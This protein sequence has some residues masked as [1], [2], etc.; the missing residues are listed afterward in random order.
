MRR[1][2][3]FG[4][5]LAFMVA[6][7]PAAP[8]FAQ[9]DAPFCG[10]LSDDDCAILEASA[11][12]DEASNEGAYD[13]ALD[14]VLEGV[15]NAPFDN[16]AFTLLHSA[17]YRTDADAAEEMA[18]MGDMGDEMLQDA[19]M[20]SKIVTTLVNGVDTQQTLTIQFPADVAEA[21]G[22]QMGA[23]LPEEITIN[24]AI[25]DG[26]GYLDLD[27]V[28][29]SF[30]EAEGLTGW[31]GTELAPILEE[32]LAQAADDPDFQAAMAPAM[33]G[34]AGQQMAEEQAEIF[35]QYID[36]QRL[37]DAEIDGEA[38]AVFQSKFDFV[39]FATDPAFFDVIVQQLEALGEDA[40]SPAELAQ[41]QFM[42][43]MIA[44]MLF[45]GLDQSTTSYISLDTDY[46]LLG[47]LVFEWDLSTLAG[48]A[49]FA[50]DAL[51]ELP[52]F[53]GMNVTVDSYD[54]DDA[55]D[56]DAPE[57]AMVVPAEDILASMQ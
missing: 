4:L 35:E 14:V 15:P 42:M 56:I 54:Q 20:M 6:L 57:G 7:L 23:P 47:E 5:V 33:M 32:V 44:P 9:D 45:G 46:T 27:S 29:A 41:F 34:M 13:L 30:P 11:A 43:P 36:I 31:V 37:D 18:M 8:V 3:A 25:V 17:V 52:S 51:G 12:A 16:F 21:L 10:N 28:A 55:G 26:I 38:V 22:A 53:F 49:A 1:L 19:E 39:S 50:G 24:F 40:P 48:L 2:L